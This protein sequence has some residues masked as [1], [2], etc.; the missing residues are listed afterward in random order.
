MSKT[1][2]LVHPGRFAIKFRIVAAIEKENILLLTQLLVKLKH[3]PT[4]PVD[5]LGN[6]ML[7]MACYI[8]SLT[9]VQ[10]IYNTFQLPLNEYNTD[11]VAPIHLAV[12]SCNPKVV[13][14]LW[15]H[16]ADCHVP[17]QVF[18]ITPIQKCCTMLADRTYISA[19][20]Q[21]L[22]IKKFLLEKYFEDMRGYEI[23][24]FLWCAKKLRGSNT[25][26]GRLPPGLI[27]EIAEYI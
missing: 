27:R 14:W 21:L 11:G 19:R 6:N 8:G 22:K 24:K 4:D 18:G 17:T 9:M 15:E 12:R 26:L 13:R 2:S 20:K 5:K 3:S 23:R 1:S 25:E 10:H 7:H 16:G